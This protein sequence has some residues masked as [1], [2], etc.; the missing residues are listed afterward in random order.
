MIPAAFFLLIGH[1]IYD[2]TQANSLLSAIC[3]S[4]TIEERIYTMKINNH[5]SVVLLIWFLLAYN[6]S[7][8]QPKLNLKKM[9]VFYSKGQLLS[10]SKIE[11]LSRK[12]L[13]D[14][15]SERTPQFHLIYA[16]S[17]LMLSPVYLSKNKKSGFYILF[18]PP[19]HFVEPYLYFFYSESRVCVCLLNSIKA[20]ITTSFT[21]FL[22]IQKI[23]FREKI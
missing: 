10:K 5:I 2:E 4:L 18:C 15:L 9:Q 1:E 23:R 8:S 11:D 22:Q 19:H 17:A 14:S 3:Q 6:V 20:L 7:F 13:I 12:V 21:P 16:D